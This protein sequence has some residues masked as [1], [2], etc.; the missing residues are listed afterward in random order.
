MGY[1]RELVL[2]NVLRRA[3][4]SHMNTNLVQVYQLK[5]PRTGE[6]RYVG[7]SRNV[8][9]RAL[10]H[11]AERANDKV[12]SWLK[13]LKTLGLK[14]ECSVLETCDKGEWHG[15]EQY[16]IKKLRADGAALLNTR[17]SGNAVKGTLIH[18]RVSSSLFH[19]LKSFAD[20]RDMNL[21]QLIRRIVEQYLR[22]REAKA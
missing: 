4:V 10:E 6:V 12:F 5:D 7:R 17:P 1:Y 21:S 19:A 18:A 13:E 11:R 9:R 8:A 2:D 20:D 3:T 22:R 16:W 14:A 15:R